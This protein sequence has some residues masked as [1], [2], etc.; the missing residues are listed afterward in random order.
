MPLF[1][2]SDLLSI[3]SIHLLK[4]LYSISKGP[5]QK[6]KL[7]LEFNLIISV[8]SNQ[9]LILLLENFP[10]LRFHQDSTFVFHRDTKMKL[11]VTSLV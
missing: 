4:S 10:M 11:H 9:T 7:V 5:F 8:V 3:V 2:A 6:S 1:M